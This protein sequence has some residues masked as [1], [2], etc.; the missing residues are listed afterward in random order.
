MYSI[1][2][3]VFNKEEYIRKT[4]SSVLNQSFNNF[5]LIIVDDGSTDSSIKIIKSFKDDRIKLIKQENRGVSS[6][7]NKGISL[8]KG[9]YICFL[10]ADDYWKENYLEV[11]DKL[12]KEYK[13]ANMF[14]LGYELEYNLKKVVPKIVNELERGIVKNFY[15]AFSR[16]FV[17]S[18]CCTIK[19]EELLKIGLFPEDNN[20]GEDLD[21]WLRFGKNNLVAFD[22]FLGACYKRNTKSNARTRN[23]IYYPKNLLS[24]LDLYINDKS[25]LKSE[26][27]ALKKFFDKKMVV[28]IFSLINSNNKKKALEILNN[29]NEKGVY[30]IFKVILYILIYMPSNISKIIQKERMKR[31]G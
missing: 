15:T 12:I 2:I 14:V 10:D 30:R 19:K 26:R 17:N 4:I 6:A 13:E 20:I 23:S 31:I 21:L 8:A 7:R 11:L 9:E 1:I 22:P 24:N 27:K 16:N 25:I 18:S 29:W 3:P 5:E 28:Y